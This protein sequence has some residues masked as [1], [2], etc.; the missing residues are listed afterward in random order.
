MPQD[1]SS[2][3][4]Q[5]NGPIRR[6]RSFVRRA[7]RMTAGQQRAFEQQWQHYGLRLG[8]ERLEWQQVFGNDHPVMLEIGFGM[9]DSLIAMASAMPAQNFLGIEVHKEG[10]LLLK[11]D[12]SDAMG[13]QWQALLWLVNQTVA[14]GWEIEPGQLLIT[15]AI[16]KMLPASIGFYQVSYGALGHIDFYVEE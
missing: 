11:G 14:N 9:G 12:S 1:S 15:G 7:G 3:T 13:D 8:Q 6:S 16:G 5:P 4:N 10:D 2:P